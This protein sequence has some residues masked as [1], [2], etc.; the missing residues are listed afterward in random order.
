MGILDLAVQKLFMGLALNP[1]NLWNGLIMPVEP[2]LG[3]PDCP[4]SLEEGE[5]GSLTVVSKPSSNP[6]DADIGGRRGLPSTLSSS[7]ESCITFLP[8]IILCYHNTS[9]YMPRVT[10]I[11]K[12]V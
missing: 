2:V 10:R 4:S 9:T 7:S 8:A 11:S 6:T 5:L 1:R 12:R 3:C